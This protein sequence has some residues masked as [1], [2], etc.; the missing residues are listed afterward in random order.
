MRAALADLY[1]EIGGFTLAL[2]GN[3]NDVDLNMKIRRPGS[4]RS[5]SPWVRLY[6]FESKSRDPRIL[7][8]ERETLQSRWA[9]RMQVEMYSRMI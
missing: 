1:F 2:P 9:R 6:H 4:T 5:F 3:Y 7:P 8:S